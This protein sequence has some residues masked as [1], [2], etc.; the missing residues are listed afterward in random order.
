MSDAVRLDELDYWNETNLPSVA[1]LF[2]L[3][4]IAAYEWIA[5]SGIGGGVRNAADLWMRDFL[6]AWGLGHPL[7]LPGFLLAAL[8][9]WHWAG[10]HPFRCRAATYIGVVAESIAFAALLILLGHIV[11]LRVAAHSSPSSC[12]STIASFIG[13]GIYE[14]TLFRLLLLPASFAVLR[15]MRVPF[16]LAWG[17]A[18]GANAFVFATA[19]YLDT[20]SESFLPSHL[21]AAGNRVVTDP[22]QWF[23]WTFRMTAGVAFC[24]LFLFRGLAVAVGSHVCYDILVGVVIEHW[25]STQTA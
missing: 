13:A 21:V 23:G 18:I 7:M 22:S 20:G 19:H 10:E 14:E 16:H 3:P 12:I 1:I 15:L 4:L 25:L 5:S 6:S 8:W 2:L 17:V 11:C 24:L 9:I